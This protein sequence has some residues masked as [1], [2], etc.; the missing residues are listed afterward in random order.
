MYTVSYQENNTVPVKI[1]S[2][3][4]IFDTH[5]H[6]SFHLQCDFCSVYINSDPD[7]KSA[8][9]NDYD[10]HRSER[11]L[12]R[13]YKSCDKKQA[14]RD[15]K[16]AATCFD[17]QEALP[18][19]HS[20]ESIFYYNCM[21]NVTVYDLGDTN[22]FCYIWHE[23]VASQGSSKT[24]S[25]VYR[26]F[27]HDASQGVI[28]AV[29]H[30]DN[31]GGQNRNKSLVTMLWYDK[32]MLK[33]NSITHKFLVKGYSQSRGTQCMLRLNEIADHCIFT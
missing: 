30:S 16:F 2:Y 21:F 14:K 24:A 7:Q 5:F 13:E 6:I 23:G 32:Q 29:L 17:L 19:P 4:R 31:C 12:A 18:T 22:G 15:P 20:M 3:H 26:Y 9:Q 8:M 1:W 27:Q 33:C 28:Y 10:I 25:C 11:N